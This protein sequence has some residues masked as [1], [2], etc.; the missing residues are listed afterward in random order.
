MREA[1]SRPDVATDDGICLAVV[2]LML[3]AVGALK[4][5]VMTNADYACSNA[6]EA[7]KHMHSMPQA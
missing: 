4:L 6:R 2:L 5:P 3:T 7:S 1:L